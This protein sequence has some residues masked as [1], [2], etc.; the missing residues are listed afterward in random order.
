MNKDQIKQIHRQILKYTYQGRLYDAMSLI[1]AQG[2]VNVNDDSSPLAIVEQT[3]K[4]MLRY[5]V[6]GMNDPNR[7]AIFRQM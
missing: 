3:Y 6:E 2:V 5:T 4:M 1:K 7:A